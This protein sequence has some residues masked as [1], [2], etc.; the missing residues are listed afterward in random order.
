M[1]QMNY[2]LSDSHKL[3]HIAGAG[4]IQ[5]PYKRWWV[6]SEPLDVS[7]VKTINIGDLSIDFDND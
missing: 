7:K 2:L 5:G 3:G 6:F 1:K 4:Q